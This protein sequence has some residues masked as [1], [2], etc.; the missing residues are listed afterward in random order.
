MLI[1]NSSELLAKEAVITN[2][3]KEPDW[4]ADEDY[5]RVFFQP[6]FRECRPT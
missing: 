2:S 3:R 1:G 5:R 6:L 4:K